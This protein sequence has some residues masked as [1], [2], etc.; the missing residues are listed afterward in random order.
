MKLGDKN[1][2]R[3]AY[4]EQLDKKESVFARKISTEL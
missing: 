2:G 1:N 4:I 3:S